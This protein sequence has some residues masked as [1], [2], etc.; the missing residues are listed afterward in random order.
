MGH[1]LRG[2]PWPFIVNYSLWVMIMK[3]FKKPYLHDFTFAVSPLTPLIKDWQ[4]CS[5]LLICSPIFFIPFCSGET[6]PIH[7][8]TTYPFM[9]TKNQT[10]PPKKSQKPNVVISSKF[11][12]L[13][14]NCLHDIHKTG[15]E[16]LKHCASRK[17]KPI[18]ESNFQKEMPCLFHVSLCFRSEKSRTKQNR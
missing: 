1:D 18:S 5:L 16:L 4:T 12:A 17:M 14:A 15:K 10:P 9:T 8:T 13:Y 7:P 2:S 3:F 6:T 11:G